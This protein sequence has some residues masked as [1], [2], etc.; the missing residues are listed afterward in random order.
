VT[1]IISLILEP[2]VCLME[3]GLGIGGDLVRN[4]FGFISGL[5]LR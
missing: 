4:I 2:L 5:F 1:G 3:I